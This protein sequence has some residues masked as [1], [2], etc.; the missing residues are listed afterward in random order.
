MPLKSELQSAGILEPDDMALLQRVF[1]KTALEGDT[2]ID[3]ETRAAAL[4][5][6]FQ[7]GANSEEA[8]LQA[9][10]YPLNTQDQENRRHID[11]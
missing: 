7:S 3:R 4:V 2:D 6:L 8:L 10:G 1:E 9:M 11:Q 5:R